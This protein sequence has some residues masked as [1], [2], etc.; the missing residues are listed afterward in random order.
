MNYDIA[1]S[2]WLD[3]SPFIFYAY[4]ARTL[5][6]SVLP[7]HIEFTGALLFLIFTHIALST[8]FSLVLICFVM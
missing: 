8:L 7:V 2:H 1:V 3:L 4:T 5:I 6:F